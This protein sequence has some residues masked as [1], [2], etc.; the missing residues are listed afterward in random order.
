MFSLKEVIEKLE[1][2]GIRILNKYKIDGDCWIWTKYTNRKGYGQLTVNKKTW[3]VHR[4]VYTI[5]IGEIPTGLELNHKCNNTRCFRLDHLESLTPKQHQDVSINPVA[6]NSRKTH[7]NKGH[8]FTKENTRIQKGK[9]R[10]CRICRNEGK[11][12][13]YLRRKHIY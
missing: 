11:R 8:E 3:R 9:W 1:N 7:C 5:M 12:K 10:E 4:L 2:N 13:S 6:L